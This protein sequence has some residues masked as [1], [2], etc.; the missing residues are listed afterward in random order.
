MVPFYKIISNFF[1]LIRAYFYIACAKC[2]KWLH[3]NYYSGN[4]LINPLFMYYYSGM[5]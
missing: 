4:K 1:I 5:C 3:I 2:F